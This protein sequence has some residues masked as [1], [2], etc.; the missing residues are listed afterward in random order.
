MTEG[1]TRK[2]LEMLRGWEEWTATKARR[3]TI[4]GRCRKG[5]PVALRGLAWMRLTGATDLMR[6]N[7]GLYARLLDMRPVDGSSSGGGTA[8]GEAGELDA[9][10][11]AERAAA[12][13]AAAAGAPAEA[14]AGSLPAPPVAGVSGG[15]G[16]TPAPSPSPSPSGDPPQPLSSPSPSPSGTLP[17]PLSSPPPPKS[18]VDVIRLDISRTFPHLDMFRE[19]DGPGQTALFHVLVAYARHDPEVGYCQGMAFIVAL[20]L[21]FLPPEEA[22]WMLV[23]VMQGPRHGLRDLFAPGLPLVE[24][25]LHVLQ[26]LLN[27]RLPALARKLQAV[28]M[29]PTMF[30]THWVLTVFAYTF[31]LPVVVRIWD[32]FLWE[33]W[34]AAYRVALAV[35]VAFEA[36][37][38]ASCR[39]FED[40]MMAL[41]HIP[42]ALEEDGAGGDGAGAGAGAGGTPASPSASRARVGATHRSAAGAGTTPAVPP[43]LLAPGGAAG[44]D[45]AD[46]LLALSLR[47]KCRVSREQVVALEDECRA[48]VHAGVVACGPEAGTVLRSGGERGLPAKAYEEFARR[49]EVRAEAVRVQGTGGGA[50][51]VRAAAAARPVSWGRGGVTS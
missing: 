35:L 14:A 24:A 26:G 3:D 43:P 49:K 41:K 28:G 19:A 4:K 39:G 11:A 22:F 30:A 37:L 50:A 40:A 32:A 38:L 33:G 45:V 51:G 15:G 17:Q 18:V 2:W 12:G 5:I 44:H 47:P 25:R 23:S 9:D 20:F 7:P 34:K 36:P 10:Q 6:A 1:R 48:L 27:A 42:D 29:H 8:G 13:A 46:R 21:F 31:P 16:A